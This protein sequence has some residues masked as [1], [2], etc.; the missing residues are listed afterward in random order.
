MLQIRQKGQQATTQ[1]LFGLSKSSGGHS[2]GYGRYACFVRKTCQV[3]L[4]MMS[5]LFSLF[6]LIVDDTLLSLQLLA[7]RVATWACLTH[8]LL[9]HVQAQRSKPL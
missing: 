5:A 1:T 6:S 9:P 8:P 3:F 7:P 4:N 2:D